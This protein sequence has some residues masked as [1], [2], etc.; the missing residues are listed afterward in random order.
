MRWLSIPLS[1]TG[2]IWSVWTV[3][4]WAHRPTL[5]WQSSTQRAFQEEWLGDV[6]HTGPDCHVESESWCWEAPFALLLLQPHL[7]GN[8]PL[9]ENTERKKKVKWIIKKNIFPLSSESSFRI[10]PS[11]ESLIPYIIKA[12][13]ATKKRKL[14]YLIILLGNLAQIIVTE[15]FN[16]YSFTFLR[17]KIVQY[18]HNYTY[19]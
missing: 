2:G 5:S 3:W 7:D 1:Q 16:F 18:T 13:M 6:E 17:K 12:A 8:D 10:N 4:E 14:M 9:E 19:D 11:W 15:Y